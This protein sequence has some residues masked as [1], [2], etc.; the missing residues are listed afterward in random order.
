MQKQKRNA[1]RTLPSLMD[2]MKIIPVDRRLELSEPVKFPFLLPP[3]KAIPPIV[4]QIF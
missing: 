4:D 2:E 1:P 3:V